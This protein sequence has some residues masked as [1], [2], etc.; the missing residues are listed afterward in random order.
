MLTGAGNT[1][2]ANSAKDHDPDGDQIVVSGVVTGNQ[3][4]EEGTSE[5]EFTPV[6]AEGTEIIGQNADGE[7]GGGT[8]TIKPDGSYTF[9]PGSDFDYLQAGETTTTTITYQIS[10]GE[11][12]FD[13]ATL[14]VTVTGTND[15]PEFKAESFV[16]ETTE[17]G[18]KDTD[19]ESTDS[20]PNSPFAGTP[21]TSGQF[22][23]SDVD[24]DLS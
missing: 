14:T 12:G 9:N 24:N 13:T 16:G 2:G 4:S 23:F 20:T 17:Q 3:D 21:T 6:S 19:G 7:K 10:D 15:L 11:G 22:S 18:V 8:F 1:D 5:A